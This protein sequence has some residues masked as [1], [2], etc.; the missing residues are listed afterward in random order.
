MK[1]APRYN[2]I[3]S[4]CKSTN[5]TEKRSSKS[6]KIT[7]KHSAY[8]SDDDD[9]DSEPLVKRK[10]SSRSSLRNSG[11]QRP[12]QNGQGSPREVA[13]SSSQR[14][15]IRRTGDHLPLN[16]AALYQLLDDVMKHEDA[17]PFT[18]P[19]S[20]AEVPDY[21]K[22]IKT[23]MDLAK[24]KSKLNMGSYQLNEEVMKDMQLIF[25]NCDEYNVK[26]NEI[27]W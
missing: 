8:S 23:P 27:Y 19:V 6:G 24:V 14:R 9:D 1:R 15:S 25:Q 26:G 4:K 12:P 3:C 10:R 7:G 20:H 5:G 17:W 13:K 21:H 18:R 16:S 11:Y 2:F 22:I